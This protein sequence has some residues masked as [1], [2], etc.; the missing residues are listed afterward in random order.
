MFCHPNS[1]T[2]NYIEEYNETN[3]PIK[4]TKYKLDGLTI[5]FY[6]RLQ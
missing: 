6:R 5:A 2:I 4:K 3:P 1:Q